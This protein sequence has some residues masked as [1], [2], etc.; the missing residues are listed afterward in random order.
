MLT[1]GDELRRKRMANLRPRPR[2]KGQANRITRD[3]RQA[4]I[5]AAEAHGSDGAGS[6]GLTGYLFYLAD[7][8]P[9]AFAALLGKMIP[10]QLSG[11]PIQS[12]VGQVTVISIPAGHSLSNDVTRADS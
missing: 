11:S 4:I 7:S 8:H 3:L 9:K 2:V 1:A 6:N 12:V 5:A 10:L